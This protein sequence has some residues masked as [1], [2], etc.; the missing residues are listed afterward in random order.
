MMAEDSE[1]RLKKIMDKL[2]YAPRS[3]L[4]HLSRLGGGDVIP[5]K[6]SVARAVAPR[7]PVK[8]SA[9]CRPWDRMDLTRRLTTFKAMTWFGKPK[10]ISPL[11][12]ARRGWINVEMDVIVCEACGA[13]LLFS[14]PPSWA[15]QQV[16]KA[17]AVFSL[18]L[19]NGHKLLCPW[20]DNACDESLAS[21]PSSPPRV[22]VERFRERFHALLQ[23]TTLPAISS[24]TVDCISSPQLDRF[25]STP[26]HSS[27]TLNNGIRLND[28]CRSKDLYDTTED[29]DSHD[30]YQALKLISLFGWEPRLLSYTIEF[31]RKCST[32]AR[33][34]NQ[35]EASEDMPCEPTQ[36]FTKCS[37]NSHNDLGG[38]VDSYTPLDEYLYDQS[39]TVLD[40]RFCGAC[41]GLWFFKMIPRPL[42]FFKIVIDSST[43][44]EL[45][46]GTTDLA[47]GAGI[48]RV[49]HVGSDHNSNIVKPFGL[50]L[51]IAGGPPPTKQH[52]RPKISLPAVSRHI[53]AELSYNSCLRCHQG[54]LGKE[55]HTC[56]EKEFNDLY[57]TGSQPVGSL[58]R[59]RSEIEISDSQLHGGNHGGEGNGL[60]GELVCEHTFEE[61][62]CNTPFTDVI[63]R[64]AIACQIDSASKPTDTRESNDMFSILDQSNFGDAPENDHC[65]PSVSAPSSVT[66]VNPSNYSKPD[67]KGSCFQTADR[68]NVDKQDSIGFA[69]KVSVSVTEDNGVDHLLE[70]PKQTQIIDFDPIKQHRPF[71]PWIS[72]AGKNLSG[73]KATLSAL[74]DLE[75]N[76]SQQPE[77]TEAATN[78]LDEADDPIVSVRKLF[79]SPSSKRFKGS[80]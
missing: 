40:C 80:R 16:E 36:N 27:I 49:E 28:D 25:L 55:E 12:C 3:R 44:S 8:K 57:D 75:N 34:T 79:T 7:G 56:Q 67:D 77:Q 74:N 62:L 51:S 17:A 14:T 48:P 23:L 15:L 58:K 26:F 47:F 59:K 4:S 72:D 50:H 9:P 53:R 20:I 54:S 64:D 63:V 42:E 78:L 11:N 6:G 73:W 60:A 71:C 43:Q 45:A 32:S 70:N 18:K 1:N 41:I 66:N 52:F 21:F 69:K 39:S 76:S 46:T 65:D 31:E 30:Y 33:T 10:V 2:Y 19:D 37:S 5:R 61:T 24:L 68:T 35:F 38:R 29:V 13:R 22:L